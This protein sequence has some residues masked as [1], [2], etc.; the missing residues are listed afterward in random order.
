LLSIH[1]QWTDAAGRSLFAHLPQIAVPLP[2]S[3]WR[4]RLLG[5]AYLWADAPATAAALAPGLLTTFLQ[6]LLLSGVS[7]KPRAAGDDAI[8]AALSRC[9]QED[10]PSLSVG[11]LAEAAQL[12]PSRFRE[13]FRRVLGMSPVHYLQGLRLEQAARHLDA[14]DADLRT[15]AERVG[16]SSVTHFHAAFKKRFGCTPQA[17][18]LKELG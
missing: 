6:D 12:G 13:R 7:L 10:W 11:D 15:I 17:W 14:D 18:R 4:Q 9:Q 8:T 1:C 2:G 3:A 5:L 16:F